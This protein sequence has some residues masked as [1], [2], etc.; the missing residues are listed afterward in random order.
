MDNLELNIVLVF[1]AE[2]SDDVYRKN[3]RPL[4]SDR[5]FFGG[6]PCHPDLRT[7]EESQP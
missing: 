3:G 6:S 7:N 1:P 4:T 5:C 2:I